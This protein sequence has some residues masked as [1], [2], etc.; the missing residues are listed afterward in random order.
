[1]RGGG[2]GDD[3]DV[4]ARNRRLRARLHVGVSRPSVEEVEAGYDSDSATA[5]NRRLQELRRR[6]GKGGGEEG[7]AGRP[8]DG[9]ME[10]ST[11]GHEGRWSSGSRSRWRSR[12]PQRRSDGRKRALKREGDRPM[13]HRS[14]GTR[15]PWDGGSG[16]QHRDRE[17][18]RQ[19]ENGLGVSSGSRGHGGAHPAPVL[20]FRQLIPGYAAMNGVERLKAKTKYLLQRR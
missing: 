13:Q 7:K 3:D 17:G 10:N 15:E 20:D 19:H 11:M 9:G 6:S 18:H 12:S 4:V 5:V 16:R 2:G 1:V 8:H 14:R